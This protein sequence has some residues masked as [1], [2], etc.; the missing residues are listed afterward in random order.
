[1]LG[2]RLGPFGGEERPPRSFKDS[3]ITPAYNISTGKQAAE[4]PGGDAAVELSA[5]NEV[6]ELEGK[7]G[8][9]L[10]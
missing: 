8:S 10:R 3:S 2:A 4:L 5:K 7:M 9:Q 1:M 6:N